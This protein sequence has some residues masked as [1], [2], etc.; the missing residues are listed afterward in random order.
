MQSPLIATVTLNPSIDRTI[1]L[2][3]LKVGSI[4]RADSTKLDP[5]GKGVNVSRALKALGAN[6]HAILACGQLGQNWFAQS[7]TALG[8]SHDIV[9]VGGVTRT[10]MTLVESDGEVTKIN[11]AGSTLTSENLEAINKALG[12]QPIMGGWVVLAG[13]LNPG[14]APTTYRDLAKFAKDRGAR[15]AV[16]TSGEELKAAVSAGV[17]DLIKPNQHELSELVGRPLVTIHDV[18]E[19]AR[20]VIAGGVVTV[21]CSLGADGAL[22]ITA[23]TVMHCEPAHPVSGTPVGAGDILLGTFLGA[24]ADEKA[25]EIGI[26]WSAASVPLEGTS[27]PTPAQAAAIEV[28]VNKDFDQTRQLV[29]MD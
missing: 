7:L 6:T 11:E 27:I 1:H 26:A 10:N 24:G 5:G 14:L 28:R 13:R 8:I 18:I 23:T 4:N 17:V 20:S 29:D 22:L 15:V 16:D 25:L 19:A 9:S 21:L 3:E 12:A 2:K